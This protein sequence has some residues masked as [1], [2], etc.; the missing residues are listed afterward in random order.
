MECN[1][2]SA[3]FVLLSLLKKGL[4]TSS[5]KCSGI[6]CI[7]WGALVVNGIQRQIAIYCLYLFGSYLRNHT[8]LTERYAY[9][10]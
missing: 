4:F 2:T 7:K 1:F 5:K 8:L 3:S 6:F 10:L 9:C